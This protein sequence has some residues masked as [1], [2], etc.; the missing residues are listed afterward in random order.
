MKR[1]RCWPMPS[2]FEKAAI[3]IKIRAQLETTHD[4]LK[5][6]LTGLSLVTPPGFDATRYQLVKGEHL[7]DFPYQYLDCLNTLRRTRSRSARSCGGDTMLLARCCSK[8]QEFHSTNGSSLADFTSLPDMSWSFR[9]PR[10]CGSGSGARAIPCRLPMIV[11][12]RSR[13]CWRNARL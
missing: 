8:A 10:R 7:E 1:P 13:L 12:P 6:E 3:T 2:Y 5:Q 9:W 4:A 11:R